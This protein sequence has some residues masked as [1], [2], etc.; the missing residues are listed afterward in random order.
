MRMGHISA[1]TALRPGL[2]AGAGAAMVRAMLRSP[3]RLAAAAALLLAAAGCGRRTPAEQAVPDVQALLAAV[4]S[5]DAG[6]FEARI[7]RPALR[8]DLRQQ[9]MILGRANGVE[10]DGGPSD[11]AL[12]RRIG[13][14]M[15]RLVRQGTDEPLAQAPS[16][17]Q[18]GPLIRTID[19]N[20]VC[21]H[22]ASP[23]QTCLLT[24]AKEKPGWRLVA[25]PAQPDARIEVGPEPAKK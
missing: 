20:R 10:V 23:A 5:G 15:L 16:P 9:L 21:V 17:G 11:F 7:D 2:R 8:A 18:T 1:T 22:D 12:D 13:P 25:M 3:V 6:A 4:Q 24:F 14:A 19:R